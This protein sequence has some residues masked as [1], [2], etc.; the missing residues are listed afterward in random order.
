MNLSGAEV[1]ADWFKSLDTSIVPGRNGDG[2]IDMKGLFDLTDKVPAD[3][4]AAGLGAGT[5]SEISVVPASITLD[6]IDAGKEIGTTAAPTTE[7]GTT[8]AGNQPTN[9][10]EPGVEDGNDSNVGLYI[11]I[12]VAAVAVIA[13]VVVIALKKKGSKKN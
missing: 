6:D 10:V 7:G 2:T 1:S 4:K 8:T 11:G 3:V 9:P 12:A 5:I 13:V